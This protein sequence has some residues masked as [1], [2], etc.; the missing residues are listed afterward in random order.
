MEQAGEALT[1]L[2]LARTHNRDVILMDVHLPVL[3][4]LLATEILRSFPETADTPVICVTG[5]D[6]GGADARLA[7]CT[8]LLRKP[9]APHML[10][11]TV[12]AVLDSTKE[13]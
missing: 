2:E 1:G 13:P 12:A 9:V 8:S 4:G 11:E 7:C 5:Y 3:N 10:A 6:I